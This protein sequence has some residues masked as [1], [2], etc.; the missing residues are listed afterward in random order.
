MSDPKDDNVKSPAASTKKRF[1]ASDAPDVPKS[2]SRRGYVVWFHD[3]GEYLGFAWNE[4]AEEIERAHVADADHAIYF[5]TFAQ[6]AVAS[7]KFISPCRVLL[8]RGPGKRP[9]LMG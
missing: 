4:S 1:E 5:E 2:L 3:H 9:K 6:A 8:S 7:D